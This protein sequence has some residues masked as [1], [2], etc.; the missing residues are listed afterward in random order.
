M[1]S[2][3]DRAARD[4]RRAAERDQQSNQ[5]PAPP[6]HASPPTR[7][8]RAMPPGRSRPPRHDRLAQGVVCLRWSGVGLG[9]SRKAPGPE[10]AG[11]VRLASAL[12]PASLGLPRFPLQPTLA[13]SFVY[14]DL[15]VG[16]VRRTDAHRG[17][18]ISAQQGLL[19]RHYVKNSPHCVDPRGLNLS[20]ECAGRWDH[21]S[22]PPGATA[23]S[24]RGASCRSHAPPEYFPPWSRRP[25]PVQQALSLLPL[26]LDAAFLPLLPQTP[27]KQ[28][29]EKDGRE[30]REK[31]K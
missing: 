10:I 4:D 8:S 2:P 21:G 13:A 31:S 27:K 23:S 26:L 16:L 29:A 22:P 15:H 24:R 1:G 7:S 17:H 18:Q 5:P 3:V 6:P 9:H 19:L 28:P 14:L 11:V 30:K 25:T 20:S 12:A